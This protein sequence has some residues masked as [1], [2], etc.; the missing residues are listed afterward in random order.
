[1]IISILN[2]ESNYCCNKDPEFGSPIN[3]INLV[4]TKPVNC[5][6][7]ECDLPLRQWPTLESRFTQNNISQLWQSNIYVPSCLEVRRVYDVS[8][9]IF[10]SEGEYVLDMHYIFSQQ[11]MRQSK[12]T[13]SE[14]CLQKKL[15]PGAPCGTVSNNHREDHYFVK[16][17]MV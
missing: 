17:Q 14:P 9:Y 13:K 3:F 16:G 1:M 15:D 2:L 6:P 11:G 4:L 7:L 8:Q 5:Y 12:R 10:S